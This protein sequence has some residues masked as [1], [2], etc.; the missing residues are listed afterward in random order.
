MAVRNF[1][2]AAHIDDRKTTLQGGPAR[3]D[4]GLHAK[5]LQRSNGLI[6]VAAQIGC[7][8]VDGELVTTLYDDGGKELYKYTTKR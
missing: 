6:V 2:L 4:G 5:V 8:E 3:K 1:W 7:A